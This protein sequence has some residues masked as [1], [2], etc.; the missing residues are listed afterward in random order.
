MVKIQVR[1][2]DGFCRAPGHA[3]RAVLIYGADQG[4]VRE[5]SNLLLG[6]VVDD[7]RDPFRVCDLTADEAARDPARLLEEAVSLSMTGGR[8]V[9]RVRGVTDGFAATMAEVL[10]LPTG[11]TLILVEAGE[12]AARSKL[13][14]T[15]EKARDA[16]ALACYHDEGRMLE[17]VIAEELSRQGITTDGEARRLLESCLGGDRMQ[18][19]NEIAKLALYVGAGQ[20]ATAKDVENAVADSSLLSLD[21]IAHSV[22]S[23]NL[24]DLERSL[25]RALANREAPAAILAAVRRHLTQLEL[26]L[27]L[28][29][30]GVNEAQAMKS[31]G[32]RHYRAEN[33]LKAAG[34]RWNAPLVHRARDYLFDAEARCRMT[35]MPDT[36]IC[37]RALFDIA[38]TAAGNTPRGR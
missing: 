28:K 11:D 7:P 32:V 13:R 16:A 20:K 17:A 3:I 4:L 30:R 27:G 5:R 2:I 8:R 23:G 34:R 14:A 31:A 35:G 15:F 33:A 26:V 38:R 6:G 29:Q 18:T 9:V 19:R 36:T 22:S 24:D 10:K 25:G 37:R 21:R 12:L 1:E